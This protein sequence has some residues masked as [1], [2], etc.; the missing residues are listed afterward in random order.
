MTDCSEVGM[1]CVHVPG[2]CAVKCFYKKLA[3][4][5]LRIDDLAFS[6]LQLQ[7]RFTE[8]LDCSVRF[9]GR[10]MPKSDLA[11]ASSNEGA[12]GHW[13]KSFPIRTCRRQLS[14]QP[15]CRK[16]RFRRSS[17]INS[18]RVVKNAIRFSISNVP[19][20]VRTAE[21]VSRE[22]FQSERS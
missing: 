21:T 20:N 2:C 13:M 4:R 7:H 19:A 18:L 15:S 1:K 5:L 6:C 9:C 16:L 14:K 11:S 8:T 3:I 12:V 17:A 10:V 22:R